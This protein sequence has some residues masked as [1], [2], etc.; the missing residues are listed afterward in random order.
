MQDSRGSSVYL[1][2]AQGWGLSSVPVVAAFASNA[3]SAPPRARMER[4][5]G[6]DGTTTVHTSGSGITAA[7]PEG[8]QG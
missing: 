2:T 7:E 1:V 8:K 5:T 3:A 4:L 6:F